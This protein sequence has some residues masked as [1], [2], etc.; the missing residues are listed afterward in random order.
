MNDRIREL[1]PITSEKIYFNNAALGAVSVLSLAACRNYLDRVEKT[2]DP[3]DVDVIREYRLA[4]GKLLGCDKNHVALTANT[5]HGIGL[6]AAGMEW[7][8]GDNVV[9]C[10]LEFPSNVYP[11]MRHEKRGVEYRIVKNVDG[12]VDIDDIRAAVDKNTRV[13]ALSWVEF[14]NGFRHDL[15]AV[16]EIARQADALFL[17]DGIQGVGVLPFDFCETGVDAVAFGSQKWCLGMAGVGVLAVSDRC[18][19]RVDVAIPGAGSVKDV[20]PFL[21]YKLE[22]ADGASR[23]AS[24]SL[25]VTCLPPALAG[26]QFLLDVGIEKVSA[27]VRELT[28]SLAAGLDRMGFNVRSP[29]GEGEW[30]GIVAFDS[31]KTDSSDINA[32]LEKRGILAAGREGLVRLSPHVFNSAGEVEAVL[33][34]LEEIKAEP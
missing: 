34:A 31:D 30:S 13:V 33:A 18:L 16:S 22:Y 28:D 17:V 23:L 19:E 26:V 20:T 12:R 7:K 4:L 10:D 3:W 5:T 1:F 11:W 32:G 24:G 15:A 6:L 14:S 21:D 2:G 29:R 8:K 27:H 25:P 9:G